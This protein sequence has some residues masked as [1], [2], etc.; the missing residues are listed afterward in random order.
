MLV[1]RKSESEPCGEQKE[2]KGDRLLTARPPTPPRL[3]AARGR[4]LV[5]PDR[6]ARRSLRPGHDGTHLYARCRRRCRR[7]GRARLHAAR[8]MSVA[9]RGLCVTGVTRGPPKAHVCRVS[10]DPVW[11][12]LARL[13]EAIWLN[14]AGRPC[15]RCRS[16][17]QRAGTARRGW[18]EQSPDCPSSDSTL[19]QPSARVSWPIN[20]LVGWG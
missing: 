5:G 16:S 18:F 2:G 17:A 6:R 1:A 3:T 10:S 13:V 7:R 14:H 19:V 20:S 12:F 8:R 11:A 9:R 15:R 4:R